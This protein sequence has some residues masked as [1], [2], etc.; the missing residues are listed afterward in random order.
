MLTAV[1]Q[2]RAGQPVVIASARLVMAQTLR[3]KMY[4]YQVRSQS[5]PSPTIFEARGDNF[6]VKLHDRH[7]KSFDITDT[8]VWTFQLTEM[9]LCKA[10]CSGR[11]EAR[12]LNSPT[13]LRSKEF[14]YIARLHNFAGHWEKR[15]ELLHVAH[16]A[17]IIHSQNNL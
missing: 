3:G 6:L 15:D 17:M 13:A 10:Y 2:A 16:T 9:F 7:Y 4:M 1:L 12:F 14:V 11:N 8:V 5:C